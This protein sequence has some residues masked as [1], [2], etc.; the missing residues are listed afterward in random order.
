[1]IKI[2]NTGKR[3]ITFEHAG[4]RYPVKCGEH[5]EAIVPDEV[6]DQTFFKALVKTKEVI[7]AGSTDV[8]EVEDEELKVT[9]RYIE[10]K[11]LKIG[12]LRN[13]A[14]DMYEVANTSRM[15][16]YDVIKAI[17]EAEAE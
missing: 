1:M 13:M 4:K 12:E 3:L 15:K 17:I 5:N 14:K 8:V 16:E 6:A 11:D 10:L 9:E 2:L 7:N